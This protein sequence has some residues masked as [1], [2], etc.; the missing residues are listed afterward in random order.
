MEISIALVSPGNHRPSDISA[1]RPAVGQYE[2]RVFYGW[3][4]AG[5][6]MQK[7]GVFSARSVAAQQSS[8]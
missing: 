2:T 7:A 8:F 4:D 3:E 5:S 6:L 1:L